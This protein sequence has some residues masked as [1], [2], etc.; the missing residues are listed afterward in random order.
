MYEVNGLYE[1]KVKKE[2]LAENFC[3]YRRW[4]M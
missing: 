2:K 1:T 4:F 3:F